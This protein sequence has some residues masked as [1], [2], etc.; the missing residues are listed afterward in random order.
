LRICDEHRAILGLRVAM[1]AP[2][3]RKVCNPRQHE[4][5]NYVPVT[6]TK[7]TFPVLRISPCHTIAVLAQLLQAPV[8]RTE[9]CRIHRN[10]YGSNGK[11]LWLRCGRTS[12][13]CSLQPLHGFRKFMLLY[14]QLRMKRQVLGGVFVSHYQ[15]QWSGS[16]CIRFYS[17]VC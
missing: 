3:T 17:E 5:S 15:I 6:T 9:I 7:H 2:P 8:S 14:R 10:Y 16:E 1:Q 11:F 12:L 4:R 13:A